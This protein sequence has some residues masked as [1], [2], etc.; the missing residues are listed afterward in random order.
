MSELKTGLVLEGGGMRGMYTAAI[1]D[2]FMEEG[3]T[4]DGVIGVSAGAIHGGSFLSH[5]IG[6]N[7]RYYK[8]YCMDDR[9][10]SVKNL[11]TT[12]DMVGTQFCYH[13]LPERLDPV[14]YDTFH[15]NAEQIAYHVVCFDIE[16][17]K[18]IYPRITDLKTQIDYLRGSGSLPFISQIV[19][20]DGRKL[21][22]GSCS[23]SVPIRAFRRMGYEK[24]V[25]ILTREAG[26][27]KAPEKVWPYLIR[28]R[29][30]PNL[31]K[32]IKHRHETYNKTLRYI[33]KL[34]QAGTVFVFRP[35]TAPDVGRMERD[36]EKLQRVYDMGRA[37]ALLRLDEL[38][39]W[40]E[41]A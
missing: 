8:T 36:P 38:K 10:I 32:A 39:A 23:D 6:R 15:A 40:M 21:L 28:Y 9:F 16:T 4:F 20:V 41:R 18:A 14:D 2:V 24:N 13:E 30:Y 7:L 33:E 3:L 19:E 11:I 26:Y 27:V 12:G 35:S 5:Q 25:I 22:D 17:G 1:L 34:E 37:D 31:I 29:K